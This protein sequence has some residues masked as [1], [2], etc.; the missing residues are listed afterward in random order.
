MI[1]WNIVETLDGSPLISGPIKHE[2]LLVQVYIG[3]WWEQVRFSLINYPNF[4]LI[5]GILLLSQHDPCI[6]WSQWSIQFS[7]KYCR[8]QC[9]QQSALE[10]RLGEVGYLEEILPSLVAT[11]VQ[12]QESIFPDKYLAFQAVWRGVG[13]AESLHHPFDCYI[14]L[15]PAKILFGCICSMSKLE[16][17]TSPAGTPVLFVTICYWYKPTRTLCSTGEALLVVPPNWTNVI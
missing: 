14:D 15:Q 1:L 7:T 9:L 11:S 10:S 2:T 8:T 3:K 5:L 17:L 12:P 4:T 6:L 16:Y 13:N